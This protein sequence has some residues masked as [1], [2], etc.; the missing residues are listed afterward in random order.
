MTRTKTISAMFEDHFNEIMA[1]FDFA[2]AVEMMRAVNFGWVGMRI[3][4]Q[5]DI[6]QE[7][8]EKATRKLAVRLL[9]AAIKSCQE[10][11]DKYWVSSGGFAAT[12]E[13]N[14][15]LSLEF[16]PVNWYVN[17]ADRVTEED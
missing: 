1:E 17:P 10:S 5:P 13:P 15:Y 2:R 9:R 12:A 7:E 8:L 3:A 6:S 11:E 4:L 16:V 14:G